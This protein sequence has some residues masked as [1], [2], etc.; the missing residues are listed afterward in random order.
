MNRH[1]SRRAVVRGSIAAALTARMHAGRARAAQPAFSLP[2]GLPNRTLGDGFFIRHGYA[3]EHTWYNPGWRHTGEDWYL[4]EGETAGAEVYAVADGAVVFAGSNYPG[5]VVIVQHA[6]ALYSMYGHLEGELAVALGDQVA[7]G[8]LLGT[9]FMRTDGRAPSHLHFE[10]RTFL[11]NPDVNG[12]APRYAYGCG[13]QCPPGPGYWPIDAPEHPSDMGWRNPTHVLAH[14]DQG[15][16][17]RPA[18]VIV[19]MGA[20]AAATLWSAPAD[21]ADADRRGELPLTAGD[22]YRLISIAT[23][24]AASHGT[25][26]EAY[27]L[28]YRLALPDGDRAWVQTALPSTTD[29]GSDGRPSSIRFNLLPAFA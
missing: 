7:R 29:T 9:V 1:A 2:I 3:C 23:G 22:R 18:E 19:A 10:L 21:H 6:A 14:R 11:T 20:A 5:L 26:A 13:F 17:Q 24:Q 4:L 12:D 8:Q 15:D 28:W 25:S 16:G 27:R